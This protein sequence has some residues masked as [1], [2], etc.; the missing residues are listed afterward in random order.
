M[1]IIL[2]FFI[3][4]T[5]SSFFL[6]FLLLLL[7]LLRH[8]AFH[9]LLLLLSSL[10]SSLDFILLNHYKCISFT[11]MTRTIVCF[12]LSK[13]WFCCLPLSNLFSS[14][15][16]SFLLC[17]PLPPY[18][19]LFSCVSYYISMVFSLRIYRRQNL[20]KNKLAFKFRSSVD[21]FAFQCKIDVMDW[22][23]FATLGY[24]PCSCCPLLYIPTSTSVIN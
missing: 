13:N 3:S 4:F 1:S 21:Y 19:L 9:L 18:S 14:T 2:F 8:A 20:R 17:L 12:R 6:F 15:F 11:D 23:T 5:P 10:V 24:L 22:Q 7:L 16:Y